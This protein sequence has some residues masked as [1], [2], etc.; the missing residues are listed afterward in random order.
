M[1]RVAASRLI[2]IFLKGY[3]YSI[4]PMVTSHTVQSQL[5]FSSSSLDGQT[6]IIANTICYN[7]TILNSLL[8]TNVA[9]VRF[10]EQKE[11]LNAKT[12]II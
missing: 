11:F 5:T 3:L 10:F 4:P 12:F 8:V 1:S 7:K 2:V 9:K 6:I